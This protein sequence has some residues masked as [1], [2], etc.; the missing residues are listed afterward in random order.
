GRPVG[1]EELDPAEEVIGGASAYPGCENLRMIKQ[2][3]LRTD[4]GWLIDPAALTRLLVRLSR[5]VP[6]VP[7]M[8]TENGAAY[9]AAPDGNGGRVHDEA[10]IEYLRG[11]VRAVHDAI[12]AGAD[13]RGYFVWSLLDNFEWAW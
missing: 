4:M 3:G 11:H 7:L 2:P 6:G 8:V 1:T 13:V 12:R 10:R 5:D 9:H